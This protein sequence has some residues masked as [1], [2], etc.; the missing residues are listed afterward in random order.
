MHKHGWLKTGEYGIMMVIKEPEH[1]T[2]EC[3]FGVQRLLPLLD[4]F[5]KEI[6]GVRTAQDIEH[7]HRMRVASRRLRAA[8][9][10]F[11]ACFPEKKY[12]QWIEE[13]RKVTRALGEARDTDVQIAFLLKLIKKRAARIHAA[14][15]KTLSIRLNDDM[16]TILLSALQKKRSKLQTV[17]VSS[18]EKLESSGVIDEMRGVF[19]EHE[20]QAIRTRKKPSTYGL[21]PVAASRIAIRLTKLLSY[22]GWVHNPDAIAEHHAIRIAAKKLRYT[23]EVYSPL[24]RRGLKKPLARVKKIQEILGDLHDCDVWIDQVMVMLV[25]E[26]LTS[27]ATPGRENKRVSNVTKYKHFLAEREKERKILYLRF[28]RFWDSLQR[29]RLW[30]EL[31]KNL[32]TGR[33]LKYQLPGVHHD[34]DIRLAVFNLAALYAEGLIHSRKVTDLALKLFDDLKPLHRMQARERFLLECAGQLHD[35]G[36]KFGQKGHSGRSAEMIL[37]HENLPLDIIDR[38]IIGLVAKAHRGKI[39]FESEGFFSLL[40]YDNRNNVLMLAALLRVADGLDYLH[41]GSAESVHCIINPHEIILEI[42]AQR[43]ISAEKEHALRK[44]DLFNRVFE[45]NLVIR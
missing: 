20:I 28:V 34:N 6:D 12:Q 1:L 9:P 37:S 42:S 27:T 38:G 26:R 4:A 21:A 17:V 33:K 19:H 3:I 35:I 32:D 13:I 15:D 18:L 14:P 31:R 22:E 25:K 7:I 41:L 8:L 5:S 10:L 40:S 43:D 11:S 44:S 23:I 39:R 30:D 24:Y 45:R 29:F 2:A 36:W 16:E